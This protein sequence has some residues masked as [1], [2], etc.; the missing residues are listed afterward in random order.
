MDLL[1]SIDRLDKAVRNLRIEWEKFFNGAIAVPPEDL[2]DE[3]GS[4]IRRLR[5]S[6]LRGVAENYRLTQVEA[7]YNSY[8]E[9][10]GRRLRH[11]EEGRGPGLAPLKDRAPRRDPRQGV[12]L[13]DGV[14]TAAAEVLYE[15]L[16][17]AGQGPRF[18]LESFRGYLEK[19]LGALK[20]KTGCTQVRFR[21]EPDGDTMKL[22]AK[23]L[24]D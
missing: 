16:A 1:Q 10:Y 8:S 21:L 2:R 4:E 23:P 7:R 9:L 20:A 15:G 19:Q 14:D 5:N 12:I 22:K 6:N 13:T 3:I 24:R 11:S 17:K 18:D